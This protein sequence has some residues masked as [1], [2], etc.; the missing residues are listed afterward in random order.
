MHTETIPPSLLDTLPPGTYE[1]LESVKPISAHLL[2]KELGD[3]MPRDSMPPEIH[4]EMDMKE[5]WDVE[6]LIL[7]PEDEEAWFKESLDASI[8]QRPTTQNLKIVKAI[9]P[10]KIERFWVL[11]TIAIALAGVVAAYLML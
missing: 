3:F 9:K 5:E 1:I 8:R 7:T 2:N 10:L 11:T 6:G 4:P